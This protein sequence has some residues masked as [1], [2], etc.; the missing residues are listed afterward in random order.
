MKD[1][2]IDPLFHEETFHRQ[3]RKEQ[4][5]ERKIASRTDRSKYKKTDQKKKS[6]EISREGLEE[7]LVTSISPEGIVVET[8][9]QSHLCSL[10]GALKKERERQK[11]LIA[12]GDRVLFEEK[13]VIV[14]I[15]PRISILSRAETLSQKKEQIIAVNID[16]VL[17]T[18][19]VVS[20]PLKPPIVDRYMIAARKGNMQPVIVINKVDLLDESAE[21]K[22]LY[23]EFCEAYAPL[24]IPILPISVHKNI[25]IDALREIM[26]G[27]TSVFSGQSGVGKSSLINAVTGLSLPTR[28]VVSKTKKGAHTTTSAHLIHLQS[29]GFCV[30]TPGIK[31]FGLWEVEKEE[32]A[33]FFPDFIPF[34]N[35]CRFPNCT[36]LHEPGCAV[37][38]A[39]E[40]GKISRL[41]FGSYYAL[42]TTISEKHQKR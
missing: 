15:L 25:G 4:R 27:K 28:E 7:G 2:S 36:H 19:S 42:M 39:V 22:K 31:S 35:N 26:R 21:E 6:E 11:N 30:D 14:H 17:I 41:R 29:G 20:P 37:E 24:N 18:V 10:K 12:I 38:N 13:G 33:H 8:E 5:K 23:Q 1:D 16:Q 34:A 32:L 40:E 3:D 9:N